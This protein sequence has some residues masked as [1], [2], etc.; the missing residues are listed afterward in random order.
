M[1]IRIEGFA[2]V[3]EEGMLADAKGAM[4][5]ELVIDA[6]QEFLSGRLD[7]ADLLVHGRNSHEKQPWSARRHR[8]IASRKIKSVA[9]FEH[10]PRALIW[11]PAGASL[12]GAAAMLGV[13]LGMA[14]ILCGPQI[15]G[16]FL[17][18]YDIFHLSQVAGLRMP[19]GLGVFPQV[20]QLCPKAVLAAN[21]LAKVWE[22]H[23]DLS[24]VVMVSTWRRQ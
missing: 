3:S 1:V 22:R 12:E 16:L 5:S 4:P 19:G 18:R 13:R 11:N 21:G 17:P 24:S 8:L 14:A 6:D 23:L 2:I 9:S 10:H 7:R 20:P 15:Y